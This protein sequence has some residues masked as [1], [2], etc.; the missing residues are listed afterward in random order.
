MPRDDRDERA[1]VAAGRA[2]G[3]DHRGKRHVV[4]GGHPNLL[5]EPIRHPRERGENQ[6]HSHIVPATGLRVF[7]SNGLSSGA[8][9]SRRQPPNLR[10]VPVDLY[11]NRSA[12]KKVY[13]KL[14]KALS[15]KF[16]FAEDKLAD[17]HVLDKVEEMIDAS[18][19]GSVSTT[20]RNGTRTSRLSTGSRNRVRS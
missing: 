7:P 11:T 13:T 9:P 3:L 17:V 16:V 5:P 1:R 14:E 6:A 4:L 18:A 2:D 10:R 20:S 19:F 8:G 12:Y 15:V